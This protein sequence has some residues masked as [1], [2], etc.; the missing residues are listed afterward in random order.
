MDLTDLLETDRYLDALG[1]HIRRD[2]ERALN[3]PRLVKFS[4]NEVTAFDIFGE[5]IPELSGEYTDELKAL[6][7]AA[8][9]EKTEYVDIEPA[10]G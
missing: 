7:D 4:E 5:K 9:D 1:K 3:K 8:K 10:E 2:W 6:L